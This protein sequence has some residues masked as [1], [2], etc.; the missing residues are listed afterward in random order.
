MTT[1]TE[2]L[3]QALSDGQARSSLELH[4]RTGIPRTKVGA[5]LAWE[6]RK[7][8]IE[9]LKEV[10]RDVLYRKAD[11][12]AVQI[13]RAAQFLKSVGYIVADQHGNLI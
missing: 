6:I 8:R 3:R 12:R 2:L 4:Q 11:Q 10:G 7:G 13:E 9:T 1:K 5:L